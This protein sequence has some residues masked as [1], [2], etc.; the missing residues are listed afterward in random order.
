MFLIASSVN[1]GSR[2][3]SLPNWTTATSSE[4]ENLIVWY[5][6]SKPS[7]LHSKGACFGEDFGSM[8][9]FSRVHFAG[10]GFFSLTP[11]SKYK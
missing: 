3:V 10:L 11:P 5:C 9:S 4:D 6:L 7:I 8:I 1:F 2:S